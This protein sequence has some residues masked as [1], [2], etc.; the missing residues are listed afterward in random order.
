[1]GDKSRSSKQHYG[2]GL[3]IANT[4]VIQHKGTLTLGN[5]RKTGGAE[6]VI[7]IPLGEASVAEKQICRER[8]GLCCLPQR[9]SSLPAE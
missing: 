8:K 1:M 4:I 7:K 9:K 3:Y 6:V 5:S 2:M